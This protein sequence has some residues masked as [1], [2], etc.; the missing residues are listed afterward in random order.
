[1]RCHIL[2]TLLHKEARRHL[3]SR[4]GL[5][6][7]GLLVLASAGLALL[8]KGY[9]VFLPGNV[10]ACF[11][12][13][14]QDGPWIEHL[15]GSVP[16]ELERHIK[17]RAIEQVAAAGE[18]I[19]YP[20]GAGA[21]QV[22][23]A[24]DGHSGHGCKV[25]IWYPG[26]HRTVMARFESWFWQETARYFRQHGQH[27]AAQGSTVAIPDLEIEHSALAGTAGMAP[28]IALVIF[29]IF[30]TCVYLLPLWMCEERERGL[31]LAVA[32]TPATALEMLAARS[33]LCAIL[34]IALAA[35]VAGITAPAV[36]GQGLFWL[37]LS[38]AA[39]AAVGVGSTIGCLAR[40]QRTASLAALGYMVAVACVLSA[41][42]GIGL[43]ALACLAVEYHIPRIVHAALSGTIDG[44]QG[45]H[46]V[47]AIALA[48]M[49]TCLATALFRQRG[50]Q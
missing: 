3:C 24:G 29:P 8:G 19:Y 36:L 22:R 7:A 38:I 12:D 30:L 37:A 23:G 35:L 11:V 39:L 41:G 25:W 45:G 47:A 2:I 40:R 16:P 33:L 31:L 20:A 4:A 9:D 48:L 6:F 27:V 10:D 15:R 44:G 18:T 34:G 14:W 5:A 49:W 50:W 46:V 17:F 21:I 13:Y 26:T 43:P 42:A 32:L 1:M 28:T